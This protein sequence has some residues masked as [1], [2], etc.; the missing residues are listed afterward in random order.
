M[1]SIVQRRG[2]GYIAAV[3]GIAVSNSHL[4]AISRPAQ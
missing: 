1:D 4:R 2:I 3:L